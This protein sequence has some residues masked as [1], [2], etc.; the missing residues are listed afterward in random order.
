MP[1]PLHRPIFLL[2]PLLI[3][4]C[5]VYD[6]YGYGWVAD[7]KL[8][9]PTPVQL[10]DNAPSISQRFRP[11]DPPVTEHRGFDILIPAR[12]PVLAAAAGVVSRVSVSLR[13]GREIAIDHDRAVDGIRLQTRYFHLAEQVVAEGD[14]VRRGQLIGYSG[15][16]G[17]A[18]VYPHLHFEV[19]RLDDTNPG[20]TLRVLDP[21]LFWVDGPG[22]ITC[23]DRDRG[24]R[25]SPAR[26]T[27][28][29]PCLGLEWE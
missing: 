26:L 14:G 1:A 2:L 28:P 8:T 21:Q 25:R 23:F 15:A 20:A 7:S 9:R 5:G 22:Q 10:P 12:T 4:G 13:F 3:A 29:A 16:S 19:H 11:Q 17:M 6:K 24:F 27:Y 18:G